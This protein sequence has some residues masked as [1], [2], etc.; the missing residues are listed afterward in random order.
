[1][2]LSELRGFLASRHGTT[3]LQTSTEGS[4]VA[5]AEGAL[6]REEGWTWKSRT[7]EGGLQNG[8]PKTGFSQEFW[9]NVLCD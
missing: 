5:E 7:E 4:G 9:L 3:L 1:M 8:H 6:S 2:G